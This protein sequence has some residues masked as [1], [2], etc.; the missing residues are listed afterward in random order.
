MARFYSTLLRCS[1][2]T[3][4]GIAFL[5]V[6]VFKTPEESVLDLLD[7]PGDCRYRPWLPMC[8]RGGN[9]QHGFWRQFSDK[10]ASLGWKFPCL[11]WFAT[12]S[13]GPEGDRHRQH[14]HATVGS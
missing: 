14:L 4:H 9:R 13:F 1:Y 8:Q 11:L 12:T 5:A 2:S 10:T 3:V 6:M 7:D